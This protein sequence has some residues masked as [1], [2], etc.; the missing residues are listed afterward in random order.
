MNGLDDKGVEDIRKLLRQMQNEGCSI[1]LSS[2]NKEDI[3]L[4]CDEVFIEWIK[5]L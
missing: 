2:H 1:L 4:L 3:D 5:V